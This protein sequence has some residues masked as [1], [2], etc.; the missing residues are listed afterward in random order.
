[1]SGTLQAVLWIAGILLGLFLLDRLFTWMES[2]GW[3]YWRK[4]HGSPGAVGNALLNVQAVFEP[5]KRHMAEERRAERA[6]EDDEGGPDD[7]E[8]GH[9]KG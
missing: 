1:M 2:R 8:K 6:E 4:K 7:P 5:E 3:L 9:P